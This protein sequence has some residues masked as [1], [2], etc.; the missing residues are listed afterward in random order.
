M[1]I[2]AALHQGDDMVADNADT[3][4]GTTGGVWAPSELGD[5][6]DVRRSA[7]A[8]VRAVPQHPHTPPNESESNRGTD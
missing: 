2:D 6:T 3:K 7:S 4:R 5:V 8:P 1:R